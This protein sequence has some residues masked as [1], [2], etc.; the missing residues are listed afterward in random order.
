MKKPIVPR[1]LTIVA[2]S[3]LVG[4]M[5][6]ADN[7][8]ADGAM[9]FDRLKDLDRERFSD[10][11]QKQVWPL[12]VRNGKDGCVGC[13]HSQHRSTLRFTGKPDPDFRKL[14]RD[15]FF[16]VDDPG[17]MLHVVSTTN[18]RTQMPPGNRPRWSKKD[19]QVLKQFV[20]DLDKFQQK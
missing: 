13:H 1:F 3:L 18:K 19:I 11:F 12:L 17:S 15:G 2:V 5:A 20:Q 16:L 6:G 7:G 14:L 9:N 10:R 8:L 4:L